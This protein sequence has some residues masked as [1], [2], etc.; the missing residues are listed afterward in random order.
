MRLVESCPFRIE[1][2][3]EPRQTEMKAVLIELVVQVGFDKRVQG[4]QQVGPSPSGSLPL[5]LVGPSTNGRAPA[6]YSG[7]ILEYVWLFMEDAE[8]ERMCKSCPFVFMVN[9]S[10]K[11]WAKGSQNV[12]LAN[13]IKKTSFKFWMM[14]KWHGWHGWQGWYP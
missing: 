10:I 3:V 12:N 1:A 2:Q 11:K 8:L 9:W 14:H 6:S 7:G 13:A 4:L 5:L